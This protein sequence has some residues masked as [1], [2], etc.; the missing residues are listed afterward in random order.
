MK[1]ALIAALFACLG[2]LLFAGPGQ[3]PS[4]LGI[5]DAEAAPNGPKT[6]KKRPE[7]PKGK[8][9]KTHE[10]CPSPT[11]MCLTPR[12]Y[13]HKSRYCLRN[14]CVIRSQP[15]VDCSANDTVRC[16]DSRHLETTTC[17]CNMD[18][19]KPKCSCETESELCRFP[20]N[21]CREGQC[22]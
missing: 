5:N 1:R 3:E 10:Q 14:K 21:R 22:R 7:A 2:I 4:S 11:N 15:L 17:E 8:A 13:Q 9:C 16:S 6:E 19:G 12:T 20:R 18:A